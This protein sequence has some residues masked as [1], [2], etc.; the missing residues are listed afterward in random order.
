M[1][2]Y[3]LVYF[4]LRGRG[5]PIR[6]VMAAAE[7]QYEDVRYNKE[8]EWPFKKPGNNQRSQVKMAPEVMLV[9]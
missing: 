2:Q 5:E 6:W 9:S 4:N 8:T 7:L 3:K 1:P